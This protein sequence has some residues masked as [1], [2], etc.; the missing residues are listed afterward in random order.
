LESRFKLPFRLYIIHSN[1]SVVNHVT[2][3]FSKFLVCCGLMIS[4]IFDKLC[5]Y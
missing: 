3:I 1:H 2:K 4:P 5:S